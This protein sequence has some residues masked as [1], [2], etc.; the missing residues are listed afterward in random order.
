MTDLE[1]SFLNLQQQA[2]ELAAITKQI[3]AALLRANSAQLVAEAVAATAVA[4][5]QQLESLHTAI[6]AT[7]ARLST[8][9]SPPKGVG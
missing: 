5:T 7:L 1:T 8:C 3:Q 6:L 9:L 4:A 2:R